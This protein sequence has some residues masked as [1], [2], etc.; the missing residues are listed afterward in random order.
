MN[1]R[2]EKKRGILRRACC[3]LLC[4]GLFLSQESL[5]LAKSSG[6]SQKQDDKAAVFNVTDQMLDKAAEIGRANTPG[7]MYVSL[8]GTEQMQAVRIRLGC[9]WI[10][11]NC[12]GE[13]P[14]Q[15]SLQTT[16]GH[17]TL[18]EEV[19]QRLTAQSLEDDILE[20]FLA[21]VAMSRK[22]R[23]LYGKNAE[24]WQLTCSV[25]GEKVSGL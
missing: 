4:L 8:S 15:I 21:K 2:N 7:I 16:I 19:Q 9:K 13:D 17:M 12:R 25:G 3:L 20:F 11:N 22:Q 18:D 6:T 14:L 5:A 24:M 10:S 1:G 23:A